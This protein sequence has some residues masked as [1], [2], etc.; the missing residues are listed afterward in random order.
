[1]PI[2]SSEKEDWKDGLHGDGVR[3]KLLEFA[4]IGWNQSPKTSAISGFRG[5]HSWV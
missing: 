1:M 5:S 3:E 2:M 4:E